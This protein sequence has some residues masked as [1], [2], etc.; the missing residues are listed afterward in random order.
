LT[1]NEF[2][3]VKKLNA[4][5]EYF[6]GGHVYVEP[7]LVQLAAGSTLVSGTVTGGV[8]YD[9]DTDV[10]GVKGP[11]SPLAVVVMTLHGLPQL[12]TSNG[13]PGLFETLE[14]LAVM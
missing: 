9:E 5:D 10:A 4:P 3:E 13:L 2:P 1:V 12:T 14:L 8:K 7:E 11:L 6:P